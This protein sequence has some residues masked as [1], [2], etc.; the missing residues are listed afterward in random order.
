MK[1][2]TKQVQ[3]ET[4]ERVTITLPTTL[5]EQIKDYWHSRRLG[6]NSEAIRKLV[7]A[8]LKA[9]KRKT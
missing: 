7:E 5:A 9:E 2:S 4:I 3:V 1:G 6:S 8:G